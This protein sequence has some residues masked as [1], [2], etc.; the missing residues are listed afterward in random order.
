MKLKPSPPPEAPSTEDESL[1]LERFLP[2]RLSVLMLRV[3]NAIARSYERRFDLSVP[4]WR[5]MAVLGRFGPL[6][7]MGVGEKTQMDKV[8]VSRAVAR[9]VSAGR[10]SRRTDA[11]DRR[12][13]VLALTPAGRAIHRQIVPHAQR[14]EARLLA[15]LTEEERGALDHLL[16]KLEA[17]AETPFVAEAE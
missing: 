10:V 2:Y 6:S 13:A 5:V 3:S 12:R 17:R 11:A 14:V 1:I 16:D 8:R 7:A 15:G 9:L 4:E